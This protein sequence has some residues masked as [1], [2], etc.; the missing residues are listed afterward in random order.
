M[1][2]FHLHEPRGCL[3]MRKRGTDEKY[4]ML[5]EV[6]AKGGVRAFVAF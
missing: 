2:L 1:N 6:E 5:G 3:G 4:G